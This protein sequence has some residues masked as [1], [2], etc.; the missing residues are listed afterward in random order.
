[1]TLI[2]KIENKIMY[3]ILKIEQKTVIP[4][5]Y[6]TTIIIGLDLT[7]TTVGMK[8][9]LDEGNMITLMFM[10]KF[11]VLYGL[12]MSIIGKTILVISPFVVYKFIDKELNTFFIG[13]P[14]R[15]IYWILYMTLV[16]MVII[17]TLIADVS[18]TIMIMN[19]IK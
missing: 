16:L 10:N 5:I 6:M 2:N 19:I 9:G 13:V 17:T 1:M 15:N 11:G 3:N 14:L 18:N 8:F 7:T 12:L 4:F